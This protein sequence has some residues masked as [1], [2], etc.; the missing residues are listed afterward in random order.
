MFVDSVHLHLVACLHLSNKA[1]TIL[2]A[3]SLFQVRDAV[4]GIDEPSD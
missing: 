2:S 1:K 3:F 4:V